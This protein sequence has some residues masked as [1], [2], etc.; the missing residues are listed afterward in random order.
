MVDDSNKKSNYSLSKVVEKKSD[1][2]RNADTLFFKHQKFTGDRVHLSRQKFA[3][4]FAVLSANEFM[5]Y[6]NG[7]LK[8]SDEFIKFNN[9]YYHLLSYKNSGFGL[10]NDSSTLVYDTLKFE[11]LSQHFVRINKEIFYK[12]NR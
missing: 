7:K 3:N 11:G 1:L 4:S 10:A 5:I 9:R 12:E 2:T 6:E 8:M